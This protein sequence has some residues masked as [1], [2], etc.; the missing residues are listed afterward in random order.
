MFSYT[1]LN[2][3]PGKVFY[4][5][6]VPIP[7]P[8]YP[9]GYIKA[10]TGPYSQSMSNMEDNRFLTGNA[11]IEIKSN[12]F[13]YPNPT[14]GKCILW[15]ETVDLKDADIMVSDLQGRIVYTDRQNN[16]PDGKIYIDLTGQ[17]PGSYLVK[18]SSGGYNMFNKLIIQ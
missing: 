14:T 13:L 3:P 9:E 16:I 1:D 18:V 5:V 4:N 12:F 15:S 10:G 2:V 8:C 17:A 11:E 6:R 7:D